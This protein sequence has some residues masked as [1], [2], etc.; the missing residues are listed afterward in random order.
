MNL[1]T[2]IVFIFVFVFVLL[3]FNIINISCMNVV[4]QKIVMFLAVTVFG[5]LLA[6][7]KSIRQQKPI[8]TWGSIN[9]GLYSG[10]FAFIG[11]TI[12]FDMWY[13]PET[14]NILKKTVDHKY[15]TLNIALA[16]YISLTIAFAKMF[17]C[18]FVTNSCLI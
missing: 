12:L 1:F 8:D 5:T 14:S 13:M 6:V 2:D 18:L 15:F 10:L 16:V 11:H 7:L 4:T 3:H 9:A 17:R